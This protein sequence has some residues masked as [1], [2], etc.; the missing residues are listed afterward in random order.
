MTYFLLLWLLGWSCLAQGQVGQRCDTVD[1][2][3]FRPRINWPRIK[4]NWPLHGFFCKV[5]SLLVPSDYRDPESTRFHINF[6]RYIKKGDT[7]SP[8]NHLILLP[9]G[10]GTYEESEQTT[11][12][13]LTPYLYNT[14]YYSVNIRGL[15]LQD[16]FIDIDEPTRSLE[17]IIKDGPFPIKDLTMENAARDVAMM[18]QGIKNSPI[19]TSRSRIIVYGFS[20]GSRWAHLLVSQY[21]DLVNLAFLAGIPAFSTITKPTHT[22]LLS[23]CQL[24]PFCRTMMGG[25]AEEAYKESLKNIANPDHNK[26][27]KAF[28]EHFTNFDLPKNP[29]KALSPS[30]RLLRVVRR[31]NELFS[32]SFDGPSYASS[33]VGVVLAKAINDCRYPFSF[34]AIILPKLKDYLIEFSSEKRAFA[35]KR[36]GLPIAIKDLLNEFILSFLQLTSDYNP[37]TRW[38]RMRAPDH[39]FIDSHRVSGLFPEYKRRW[40]LVESHL[41]DSRYFEE[42]PANTHTTS[43]YLFASLLDT[44]TPPDVAKD[45]F[46]RIVAPLK[47]WVLYDNFTHASGYDAHAHWKMVA[48]AINGYHSVNIIQPLLNHANNRSQLDW[49][50]SQNY[51]L[52]SLWSQVHTPT[53]GSTLSQSFQHLP[54]VL[55]TVQTF[56]KGSSPSPVARCIKVSDH[57]RYHEKFSPRVNTM[58]KERAPGDEN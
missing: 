43:V 33:Q 6:T 47:T 1:I 44:V 24:D 46:D 55:Q 29:T 48:N 5:G 19:W 35:P 11:I 50:L 21:P 56:R 38:E 36:S 17:D 58:K 40:K 7:I 12:L 30:K 2:N 22:H 51:D 23:H 53:A 26:C 15:G 10:P 37:I 14:I 52:R 57:P 42:E 16:R 31:F 20:A 18:I 49:T 4:H 25:D 39:G 45:L 13:S 41:K 28:H 32:S 8:I 27:T 9:G 3:V 34:E 54:Q